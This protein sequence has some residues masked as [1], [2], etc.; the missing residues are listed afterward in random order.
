M[1]ALALASAAAVSMLL[2][3][4]A[5][6]QDAPP[7]L[8]EVELGASFVGTSGNAQTSSTG[9]NV[10]VHRHW[11][12]WQIESLTTAIRT[13]EDGLEAK[14]RYVTSFKRAAQ[15]DAPRGLR[16]RNALERDLIAGVS[17]RSILGAGL[18]WA[19]VRTSRLTLDGISSTAWSH[20]EQIRTGT[21]ND[22]T[23]LLQIV[24]HV[25]IGAAGDTTARVSYFPDFV[26]TRAYRS[27][28]ELS[29][30]AA[31]NSRIALKL[32]YLLRYSNTPVPGFKKTDNTAT[33]SV[34]VHW[35]AAHAPEALTA[36]LDAMI[37]AAEEDSMLVKQ[38]KD[39]VP[40]V[41]D[42]GRMGVTMREMITADGRRA[43]LRDARLRH[44][45][46]RDHA[47]PPPSVGARGL[48]RQRLRTR[49]VRAG[50]PTV[51]RRRHGVHPGQRAAL[52]RRDDARA[53]C[54]RDPDAER[55]PDGVSVFCATAIRASSRNCNPA[56]ESRAK[57]RAFPEDSFG[58]VSGTVV[59][60]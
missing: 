5:A 43:D 28:A 33:A 11:T 15:P 12:A 59:A 55:L 57:A 8:W 18:N 16:E 41:Y 3:R 1:R 30:Q 7:P 35:H 38:Q 19:L 44:R 29:A 31:M 23:G 53:V 58:C 50:R 37:P 25:P 36:G 34:V 47:V 42:G 4:P 32:G 51:L 46:R 27:E 14:G 49:E 60:D 39:V 9:V 2:A 26:R 45:S 22:P 6:A 13:K 10:K 17:F 48:H 40:T 24:S 21:T 56:L 20:E 52:L 54:L